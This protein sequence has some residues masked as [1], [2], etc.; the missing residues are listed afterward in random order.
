MMRSDP[1]APVDDMLADTVQRW[2]GDLDP[3]MLLLTGAGSEIAMTGVTVAAVALL[4]GRRRPLDALTMSL[5]AGGALLLSP[6]LRRL[7]RRQRPRGRRYRLDMPNS[8]SFPSGHAM[9]SA[10]TIASLLLI[11]DSLDERCHSRE[12]RLL[13]GGAAASAVGLSRIYFGVHFASD[14]IGGQ[15]AGLLWVAAVHRWLRRSVQAR[16][17]AEALTAGAPTAAAAPASR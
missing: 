15:L 13:A 11:S 8:F 16:Q 7:F 9:G 14:V 6:I 2:C 17:N 10:A 12:A 4:L 5:G 1:V 3:A